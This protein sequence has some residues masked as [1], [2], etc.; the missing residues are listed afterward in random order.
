MLEHHWGYHF[1]SLHHGCFIEVCQS[2]QGSTG[3]SGI[4]EATD[5]IP[6]TS[7]N[8]T[9]CLCAFLK[10]Q[11]VCACFSPTYHKNFTGAHSIYTI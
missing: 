6:E 2:H 8:I 1:G 7:K 10:D 5:S 9:L 4:P 3:S 11:I